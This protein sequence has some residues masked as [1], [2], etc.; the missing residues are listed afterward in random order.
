MTPAMQ[1]LIHLSMR[2]GLHRMSVEETRRL[3]AENMQAVDEGVIDAL[4]FLQSGGSPETV[5]SLLDTSKSLINRNQIALRRV[6]IPDSPEIENTVVLAHTRPHS[7]ERDI[8]AM[9][10][11][12]ICNFYITRAGE[13]WVL[14]CQD[15][16]K[17]R[18]VGYAAFQIVSEETSEDF[19]Q[20]LNTYVTSLI[21]SRPDALALDFLLQ[22]FGGI[23]IPFFFQYGISKKLVFIPHRSLH[24]IPLHSMFV[25]VKPEPISIVPMIT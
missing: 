7:L 25:S 24:L 14:I 3:M 2:P 15:L 20:L 13:V 8:R 5:L 22:W 1:N 17:D 12:A 18:E 4:N 6:S 19:N 16:G 23:I 9:G 11:V 21:S 10:H